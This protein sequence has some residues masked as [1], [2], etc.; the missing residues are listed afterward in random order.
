MPKRKRH[1]SVKGI[2]VAAAAGVLTAGVCA[3]PEVGASNYGSGDPIYVANNRWHSWA[4]H[5]SVPDLMRTAT[6]QAFVYNYD[7]TDLVVSQYADGSF[8][9]VNVLSGPHDAVGIAYCH[10]DAQRTGTDPLRACH[11]FVVKYNPN[12]CSPVGCVTWSDVSAMQ[13]K[14][15]ACHE[16]G[17][18]VGLRHATT[19]NHP[20]PASSCM[21]TGVL[22]D[23]PG[24]H[25][26]D[27]DFINWLY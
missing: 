26:H 15:I 1:I 18:T 20:A 25:A 2:K 8:T 4:F 17:H 3:S 7:P 9:D 24:L 27:V 13:R 6:N 22:P 12:I 10:P 23:N 21:Q 11:G 5:G 19:S 16:I 14:F